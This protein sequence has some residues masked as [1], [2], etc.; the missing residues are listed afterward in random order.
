MWDLRTLGFVSVITKEKNLE[1]EVIRQCAYFRCAPAHYGLY[2]EYSDGDD[3][4]DA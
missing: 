4:D 1:L 2:I 3:D